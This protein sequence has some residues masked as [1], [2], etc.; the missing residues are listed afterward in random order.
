MTSITSTWYLTKL[1]MLPLLVYLILSIEHRLH[2]FSKALT[3]AGG[4]PGGF[5]APGGRGPP[6]RTLDR[7]EVPES[8]IA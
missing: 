3:A 6:P 1:L 7:F 2:L 8:M 5:A 4:F